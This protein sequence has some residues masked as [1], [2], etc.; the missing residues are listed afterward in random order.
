M[1]KN[2]KILLNYLIGGAFAVFLLWSIYQQV[3]RQ[4]SAITPNTWYHTGSAIWLVLAVA[5]MLV[6]S[7]LECAKWH[8]LT[9][10]VTTTGYWQAAGS[11][12][13]GIAFSIITPNRIGEYPGR[14]LYLGH[15]QTFRYINVSILGV[16]AQLSA[17]YIFGLAGLIYYNL[18][19]PSWIAKTALI[20][21]LLVNIFVGVVY[22]KFDLWRPAIEKIKWLRRFATYGKLLNRVTT[23]LQAKVMTVSLLRFAIF[24]AQ[25][26]FLLRWLN[27]S[28]PLPEGF[29]LAALFFWVLAVIP[30]IAL[31]E[32][33]LRGNICLYLFHPFSSN[34][35]G[36]LAATA[37]IWI[38]N[39]IIPSIFGSI[40]ILRMK[41]LR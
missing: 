31:T 37:G 20:A 32:L 6:N 34:V 16:M 9:N 7:S 8:M 25:F 4:L 22:W 14:V 1:N 3:I 12:L 17:V 38:L 5:L 23:Q 36:M 41:L 19:F 29:C 18:F 30:T 10:M 15:T 26:L 35:I 27:V 40:L 13:A 21:C 2:T 24:S 39:L 28:V 33:G 11:Y